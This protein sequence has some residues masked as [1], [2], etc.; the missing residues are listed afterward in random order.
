MAR[1]EYEIVTYPGYSIDYTRSNLIELVRDGYGFY[2]DSEQEV[3]TAQVRYE[4]G[5]AD[6]VYFAFNKD[7]H[8]VG[9]LSVGLWPNTGNDLFWQALQSLLQKEVDANFLACDMHGVVVHPQVRREGIASQLL[10]KM[11]EDINPQ[12][13]FGQTNVPGA[14]VLRT[15]VA[16]SYS[17]RTF[18]GFCEVTP[19]VEYKKE[20]DGH[21][22]VK[23]SFIAQEAKPNESGVYVIS[24]HVLPPNVPNTDNFSLEIQRAFEPIQ[25]IQRAMGGEQTAATVLVSVKDTVLKN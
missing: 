20:S 13:I 23:A 5:N 10:S 17:Y 12:I 8:E 9:S 2:K 18:F 25:K 6:K 7:G 1:N 11:I 24:T 4:Y 14:V 19:D 3:L 21:P 16:R 15:K 22:F